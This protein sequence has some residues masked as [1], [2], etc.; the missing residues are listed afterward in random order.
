[1]IML[2]ALLAIQPIDVRLPDGMKC[3]SAAVV[4]SSVFISYGDGKDGY[5]MKY[6]GA[7]VK[8]NSEA[9]TVHAG[10]ERGPKIAASENSVYAAWQGDYRRGPGVWFARSVDNGRT[11]EPQRNLMDAKSPGIDHVTVASQGKKVIVMWLD[12]RGGEDKNAPVTTTIWYRESGDGG[13]TFSPSAEIKV[14]AC[15]CCTFMPEYR[16]G[17]L[18]IHY[19]SGVKN[20][21]DIWVVSGVPSTG[22]W[23]GGPVSET[24]WVL[25]GC[26]M[27]GPRRAPG[28]L[29]YTIDGVCYLKA[30]GNVP[31]KL[32]PGKYPSIAATPSGPSIVTWQDGDVL[33]WKVFPSGPEAASG[34]MRVGP[35]RAVVVAPREGQPLIIH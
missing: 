18:T 35:D 12:G 29:V 27:D 5:C 16:E 7:A 14:R 10:G 6:G 9:G 15:A 33:H 31:T 25:A 24:K 4:D 30:D 2:L 34:E 3:P 26:P 28:G 1:M 11:F 21:R 19:R 17:R 32:G 23:K 22:D 13:T 20:E 8:I